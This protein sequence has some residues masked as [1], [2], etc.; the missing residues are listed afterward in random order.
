MT[1]VL[2]VTVVLCWSFTWYAIK[3]QLGAVPP[4]VSVLWRFALSAALM[5]IGLAVTGRL[6]SVP[7]SRH[8]WFA[9]MGLCLFCLNFVLIYESERFV[10]SGV[11]SVI[12]TLSTVFNIVNARLFRG[13]RPSMRTVLGAGLGVAGIVLLFGDTLIGLEAK[14]ATL[15]GIAFATCGTFIFSLGNMATF[16]AAGDGI[17]LPNAIVRA[18]TWGTVFLT[19]LVLG[20]GRPIIFDPSPRYVASLAFLSLFGT[21]IAFLAYTALLTRIGAA[22]A[23]YASILFPVI[24]LTVSTLSEGY[25]WTIWATIGAP[26]ALA[27]NVVIFSKPAAPRRSD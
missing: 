13:V 8:V 10:V 1:A 22:R 7:A 26:L 5:W 16:R 27:G 11:V 3:M 14:A 18:M 4:E 20:L 15:T 2:Y 24:A 25:Q 21:I 19:V 17:D 9:T 23:A 6:K 12:F